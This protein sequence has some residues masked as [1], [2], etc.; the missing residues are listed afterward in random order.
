[1]DMN[2]S[3]SSIRLSRRELDAFATRGYLGPKSLLTR[4][5]TA[6]LMRYLRCGQHPAPAVW[7]K[8]RGVSERFIFDLGDVPSAAR[9][10]GPASRP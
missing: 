3:D 6:L 5:Q 7:H 8:A 9:L 2:V 1:M 4:A 10:A